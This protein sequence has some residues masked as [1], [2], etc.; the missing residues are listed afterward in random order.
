VDRKNW[1]KFAEAHS[2][3]RVIQSH[4]R[5]D[6]VLPFEPATQLRDLLQSAGFSVT[7]RAF[8]G[9]HTI[10]PDILLSVGET[11]SMESALSDDA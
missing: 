5:M 10:P 7:F 6:P 1:Q 11:L 3:C 8:P 2:G 4:G 9:E